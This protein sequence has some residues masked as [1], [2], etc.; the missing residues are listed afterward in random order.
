[1]RERAALKA[2]GRPRSDFVKGED[3]PSPELPCGAD[4]GEVSETEVQ[5]GVSTIQL[6]R[7]SVSLPANP[8]L[9]Y[10]PSSQVVEGHPPPRRAK[11][12]TEMPGRW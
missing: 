5:A 3:P 8:A 2:G 12:L 4:D 1:M 10:P 6:D 9:S 11:T 7:G